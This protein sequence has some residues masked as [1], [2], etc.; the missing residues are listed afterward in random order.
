MIIITT[1]D[2][3]LKFNYKIMIWVDNNRISLFTTEK[4]HPYNK[5]GDGPE[6]PEV[7]VICDWLY[8]QVVGETLLSI[9]WDNK[10]RYSKTGISGYDKLRPLLPLKIESLSSRGKLIIIK[11]EGG[12][13]ITCNLGV[14]GKWV[15]EPMKHSN[16]HLMFGKVVGRIPRIITISK[17]LWFDDTRHQGRIDLFFTPEEIMEKFKKTGPD[18]LA[19]SIGSLDS[20]LNPVYTDEQLW[21]SWLEKIT[22]KRIANKQICA[23]LMEQKYFS[24]IGNIYKSEILYKTEIKPD[25]PLRSLTDDEIKRLLTESVETL[26]EGYVNGGS[27]IRTFLNPKGKPGMFSPIVYG[28]KKDPNGYLILKNTFKD[29]RTTHWVEEL[30]I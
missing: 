6:G 22:S 8:E 15:T 21:I 3:Q 27:T 9:V 16:L 1:K 14:E 2:I 30:Q 12:I 10:S 25:R 5:I 26:N 7:R 20:T 18:L 24:G 17:C 23:F 13:L 19:F 28:K 4:A 29:G 11:L